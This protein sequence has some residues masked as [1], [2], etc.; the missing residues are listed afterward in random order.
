MEQWR[1]VGHAVGEYV[2]NGQGDTES[3]E[4]ISDDPVVDEGL[5][6]EEDEDSTDNANPLLFL[7]DCETT[8]P[9]IYDEH[10]TEIAA[11]VIGVPA[12][13]I[14]Q[15]TFSK[16]SENNTPHFKKRF[17]KKVNSPCVISINIS[18]IREDWHQHSSVAFRKASLCFLIL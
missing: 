3:T 2:G 12:S 11:K 8:R 18:S 16:A 7:Y 1:S 10:I 5:D 6:E 14:S 13:S 9:S 4:P 15:P 17:V